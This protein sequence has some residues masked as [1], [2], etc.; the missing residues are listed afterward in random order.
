[1]R[2]S[3]I[4]TSIQGESTYAGLPCHFVRLWGC[5]LRCRYCDT[6][7]AYEEPPIELTINEIVSKIDPTGPIRLVEITGGEPLMQE[8]TPLLIK[9]LLDEGFRV[10]LETNGSLSIEG[11]DRRAIV[12]MDIK[13]PS[14]GMDQMNCL[15]NIRLLKPH[16]EVKFVIANREDFQWS[17]DFIRR[18]L[19]GLGIN[20]LFSPVYGELQPEVL[21]NWLLQWPVSARLNLQLHKVIWGPHVRAV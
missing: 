20:I 10:L 1:M 4:F 19:Q 18:Y 16:D 8:D 12:I 6:R 11:L 2:V 5:N 21:A 13:T 9:T 17:A 7:Y 3:E 14:S 15:D